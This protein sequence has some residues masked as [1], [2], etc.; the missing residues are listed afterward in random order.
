MFLLYSNL[1]NYIE[2]SVYI[3]DGISH[4]HKK[5]FVYYESM[6]FFLIESESDDD[7]NIGGMSQECIR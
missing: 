3:Y 7:V 1:K 6:L 4:S 2:A 5:S